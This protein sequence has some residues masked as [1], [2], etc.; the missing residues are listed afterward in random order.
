MAMNLQQRST[1]RAKRR[2]QTEINVTPLVDVMLVLLVIFMVTSP[3]MI[4]GVTVDLPKTKAAAIGGHDEPIALSID[5]GGAVYIQ[6]QRIKLDEIAVKLSAVAHNNKEIRIFVR[7]DR[8]VD[9]GKVMTVFAEIKNAGY[10]NVA[11]VSEALND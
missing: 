6:E 5:K 3:M 9:Y 7:G 8:G 10:H 4:T 1:G 2:L 11:L